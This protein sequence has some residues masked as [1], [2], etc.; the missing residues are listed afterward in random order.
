MKATTLVIAAHWGVISASASAGDAR[1]PPLMVSMVCETAASSPRWRVVNPEDAYA[2]ET[3]ML[4]VP[5]TLMGNGTCADFLAIPEGERIYV[6]FT[7]TK[8]PIPPA[9]EI[10]GE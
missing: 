8:S 2:Y 4:A 9:E 5:V 6:N 10:L 7:Y 3:M 1:V